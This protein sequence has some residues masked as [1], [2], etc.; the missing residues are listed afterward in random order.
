MIH[1]HMIYHGFVLGSWEF[2]SSATLVKVRILRFFFFFISNICLFQFGR[3]VGCGGSE[4]IKRK[5]LTRL[6]IRSTARS[7][8]VTFLREK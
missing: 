7:L 8:I 5:K 3:V 2:K 4:N 1:Q 6:I